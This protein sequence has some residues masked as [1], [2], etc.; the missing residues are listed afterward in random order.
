MS[1]AYQAFNFIF[2]F[3]KHGKSGSTMVQQAVNKTSG[4]RGILKSSIR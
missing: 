3:Q 1:Q 4:A 2:H